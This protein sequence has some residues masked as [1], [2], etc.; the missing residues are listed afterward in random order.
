MR[1][2]RWLLALAFPLA[3]TLPLLPA[4]DEKAPAAKQ[5]PPITWKK[6]EGQIAYCTPG[7]GPTDLWE[8]HPISAASQPGK[9]PVPGTFRYSH[10]LGVGDVNG[11][12]KADVIC[13]DGWWEQPARVEDKPWKFHAFK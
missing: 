9:K 4:A 12:G 2:R 5:A 6:T 11:D 13:T 1:S 10:G 8:M 7:K 3:V